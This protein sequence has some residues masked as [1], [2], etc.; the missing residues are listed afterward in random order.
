MTQ[1]Q[2]LLT[3]SL[4]SDDRDTLVSLLTEAAETA[5]V[6]GNRKRRD[7]L[8]YIRLVL[9]LAEFDDHNTPEEI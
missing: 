1:T 8:D 5:R 2:Q 9:E 6:A 4:W 3:L 7:H